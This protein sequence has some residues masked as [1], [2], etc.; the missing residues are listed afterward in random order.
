MLYSIV[1]VAIASV[2]ESMTINDS[3]S[4][5]YDLKNVQEVKQ[6]IFK[7]ISKMFN[8]TL[9]QFENNLGTNN[10]IL[11]SDRLQKIVNHPVHI[12]GNSGELSPSA[13]IP[14]CEFGGHE[15][16]GIKIDQFDVA[17]CNSFQAKILNDQLCYELDPNKFNVSKEDFK[18]GIT[19]Y[20]DT[21]EEKQT[22]PKD[23][24]FKIYL[25]TLG[26]YCC[27]KLN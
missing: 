2:T 20:V 9:T 13:L 26:K 6:F 16:M 17:V 10:S 5:S 1:L 7:D 18:Q 25:D 23:N 14:F 4:G 22:F 15:T 21:N 3:F 11:D 12:I 19:F 27:F 8:M 24:D